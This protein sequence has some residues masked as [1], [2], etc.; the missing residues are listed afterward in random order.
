MAKDHHIKSYGRGL[1]DINSY[2]VI[3]KLLVEILY[4]Y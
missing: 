4:C 2:I 3:N 1:E